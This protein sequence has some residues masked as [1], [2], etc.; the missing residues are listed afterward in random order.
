M[1]SGRAAVGHPVD[2]ASGVVYA[3]YE[4]VVV[5]GAAD[6]VW[7]RFYST[8]RIAEPPTAFGPGWTSRYF[9]SLIRRGHEYH[10]ET[11]DGLEVFADP[12]DLLSHGG[13]V[14]N[15][16]SF[17]ELSRHGTRHVVT[18]WD[19]ESGD[20]E[21]YVFAARRPGE[22]WPLSGIEDGTG[23]GIIVVAETVG[24]PLELRQQV[25]GRALRFHY[26]PVGLIDFVFFV[27]PD[28]KN[29]LEARYEYDGRGRL[30]AAYDALGHAE[31]FEYD[32]R[33]RLIREI[34]K[35]GGAYFFK[36]DSQ[37]RCVRTSGERQY[38]EKS[39]RFLENI[40]WTEVTDSTGAATRYAY[41]SRG[42][43]ITE[44]DP[45]GAESRTGYDTY[46]RVVTHTNASGGTTTYTY[47]QQ[48]NISQMVDALGRELNVVFNDR[49][50]PLEVTDF[51]GFIWRYTYDERGRQVLSEDPAGQRWRFVYDAAGNL[52]R[53]FDPTGASRELRY[54]PQGELAETIDWLGNPTRYRWDPFGHVV[55]RTDPLGYVTTYEYDPAHRLTQVQQPGGSRYTYKYDAAGEIVEFTDGNDRIHRATYDPYGNVVEQIGPSGNVVRYV[56]G[57]EPR[58]LH[59]I[60]NEVGRVHR[61]FHDAAGNVIREVTFDDRTLE[62]EYDRRGNCVALIKGPRQQI[63]YEYDKADQ[64]VGRRLPDGRGISFTLDAFGEVIRAENATCVVEFT[65]D[66]MGRVVKEAQ[67][68][69]E[70]EP[71]V[72]EST[73]DVLDNVTSTTSSRGFHARYEYD[74]N[75]LI[76]RLVTRGSILEFERDAAGQEVRR[77]LP[78]G[79]SLG[80][81]YDGLGQL[82][83]QRV[84]RPSP[85]AVAAPRGLFAGS[86]S[87][88]RLIIQR[89]YTYDRC[90]SVLTARDLRQGLMQYQY[91]PLERLGQVLHASGRV[92]AFEYDEANNLTRTVANGTDARLAY[93]ERG[94]LASMGDI[95]YSYDEHGRLSQKIEGAAP[96]RTRHWFFE[97]DADDQLLSVQDPA[98][99]ITEYR[100]DAFGR[101]VIK[102][103]SAGI[104]RFVWDG[105]VVLHQLGSAGADTW[106]FEPDGITPVATI[107]SQS[108]YSVIADQLGTPRELVDFSGRVVWALITSA[109]GRTIDLTAEDVTC[110]FRSPGQW[111]DEE[112]GL[113]YNR[114]RYYDAATGRFISPDPLGVLAQ[115][116]PYAYA[117]N[118]VNWLDFFGLFG[119]GK[120][121]HRATVE[122]R[123]N[124]QVVHRQTLR[125]GNMTRAEKRLGFPQSTLATHTENRAMRKVPF[126]SGDTVTIR[127]QYP[128]CSSCKG[129]MNKAAARTGARI[130]YKWKENGRTR[131]WVAGRGR[132]QRG[133]GR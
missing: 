21:R 124:G 90:Y 2:V 110:P 107:Q 91:D 8:A 44:V 96:D 119:S 13:L 75:G 1:S 81:R 14:R 133:C 36:Y 118:P 112:S 82:L 24:R 17:Q 130:V 102:A 4:D 94:R 111:L 29:H 58:R 114:F 51:G 60:H 131:T 125:S 116:N 52:T 115:L 132:Q 34:T 41:N 20:L 67:I 5:P 15:L 78:G 103:N 18:R 42:Q 61:F 89:T 100:Y 71:E 68:V 37:G 25:E 93:D 53:I 113:H 12:D 99:A 120:G 74:R 80:Q 64:L 19:P 70:F 59:E 47:D 30:A 127:G 9:S 88:D 6:L 117:P 105:H 54:S 49:H 55:Q 129:A 39:L 76:S 69:N 92:E 65:R 33:G 43:V 23:R 7:D 57:T 10:V 128:P 50:Q 86:V 87:A 66:Y 98:G 16:G 97:W 122:V 46:G 31:R 48:S 38:D 126:R 108:V 3:A 121:T 79:A 72:V 11:A 62:Y 26:T 32:D 123:R 27:L 73:Y 95:R 77:G 104:T 45:R 109:W 28:G 85:G 40:R 63:T 106:I 56:W 83:E 84:T 101:R 35:Q 22:P